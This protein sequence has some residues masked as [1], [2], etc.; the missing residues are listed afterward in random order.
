MKQ[1]IENDPRYKKSNVSIARNAVVIEYRDMKVDVVPAFERASGGYI[2]PDTHSGGRWVKTNPRRYKQMFEAVNQSRNG[3]LE[4][5]VRNVK[6]WNEKHGKPYGS[7][8]LEVMAYHHVRNQMDKNKPLNETAEEF[9]DGLPEN[10]QSKRKLDVVR[11]PVYSDETVDGYMNREDRQNARK[12]AQKAQEKIK[13]ARRLERAGKTD[14]AKAK[15]K[16]VYG[17]SFD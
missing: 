14:E 4:R 10:T 15:L 6:S 13:E 2:I 12:E 16:E 1:V 17:R 7:Y 11:D 8:H 9:F 5:F 3:K